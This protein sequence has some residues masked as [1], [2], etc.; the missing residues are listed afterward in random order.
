MQKWIVVCRTGR[1]YHTALAEVQRRQFLKHGRGAVERGWEFICLT[2]QPSEGWH[3]P[4]QT[5]YPGW[6]AL[7]EM[8]RFTGPNILTGLDTLILQDI[9][10]LV[11]FAEQVPRDQ[12]FG[13]RDFYYPQRWASGVTM[14][15]GDWSELLRLCTREQQ[16]KF[17]GDQDF[18]EHAVT[19]GM[20][21]GRLGYLQ[22]YM[23]G[24]I[25]SFK[26]HCLRCSQAP[27]EKARVCCFHGKPRPW[28]VPAEDFPWVH[29]ALTLPP[30]PLHHA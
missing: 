3:H 25:V 13:I 7:M 30:Q 28:D 1:E 6:W 24:E 21:S 4:L 15:N 18:I 19:S 12:L 23:P 9:T 26:A 2:D 14:W 27:P 22:D 10:S 5:D 8:F 29:H 20:I 11:T 17:R 16:S